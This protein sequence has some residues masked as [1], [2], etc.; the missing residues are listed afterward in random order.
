VLASV[1]GLLALFFPGPTMLSLVLLFAAY[2]LLDGISAMVATVR[3]MRA[4]GRWGLPLLQA[5]ASLLAA[6]V[7]GL[8][9]AITLL[10]FV[11]L[12]AAW[13]IVSGCLMLASAFA[14][15]EKGRGWF[16]AGGI[17]SLLYGIL[18]VVAPLIGAI[19]LTWWIGAYAIILGISLVGLALSSATR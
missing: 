3:A 15:T 9:P 18:M 11:L 7:A 10:V 13:S 6:G 16:I 14:M 8:W 1:F 5:I 12:I 2:M 4:H 19:V 17:A